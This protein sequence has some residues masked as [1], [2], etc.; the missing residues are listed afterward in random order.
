MIILLFGFFIRYSSKKLSIFLNIKD[1]L[2]YYSS[3]T[4][5]V[6]LYHSRGPFFLKE[7]ALIYVGL[8]IS[9]NIAY[10]YF[11]SKLNEGLVFL[12]HY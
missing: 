11:K 10:F 1:A 2:F 5:I 6:F 4:L 3:L 7:K 9:L 12:K 8:I